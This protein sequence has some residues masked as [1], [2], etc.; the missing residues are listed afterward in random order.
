MTN[1]TFQYVVAIGSLAVIAGIVI[2]VQSK[3][4]K[5]EQKP[6]LRKEDLLTGLG[7]VQ[8]DNIFTD[9]DEATK[10]CL[11]LSLKNTCMSLADP[12]IEY[13]PEL[14]V[15]LNPAINPFMNRDKSTY[16]YSPNKLAYPK[17]IREGLFYIQVGDNVCLHFC[18]FL[19]YNRVF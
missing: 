3:R 14:P 8:T 16:Q 12:D 5:D 7:T 19:M 18:L 10:M 13:L 2:A 9:T 4:Q 15:F 1:K 6:T 17:N 11:P